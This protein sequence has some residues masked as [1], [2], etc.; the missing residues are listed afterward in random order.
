[1]NCVKSAISTCKVLEAVARGPE[2][3]KR[4]YIKMLGVKDKLWII[5]TELEGFELKSHYITFSREKKDGR[6]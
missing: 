6:T 2:K 4:M 1:M 3:N 5:R